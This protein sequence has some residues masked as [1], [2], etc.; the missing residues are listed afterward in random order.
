MANSER[1]AEV[2][3]KRVKKNC[4]EISN[5]FFLPN[6]Q[7][8]IEITNDQKKKKAPLPGFE[9]GSTVFKA[10]VYT[11]PPNRRIQTKFI[12]LVTTPK[13]KIM[14]YQVHH[15][16]ILKKKKQSAGRAWYL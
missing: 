3:K 12:H 16:P 9:P 5:E 10:R 13:S 15:P 4:I 8:C 6:F 14:R 11:F 7:I 2:R 1:I